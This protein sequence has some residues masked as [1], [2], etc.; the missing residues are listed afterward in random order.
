MDRT[1]RFLT[2]LLMFAGL[3]IFVGLV[4]LILAIVS[5]SLTDAE[6]EPCSTYADTRLKNVPAR[7]VKE[8]TQ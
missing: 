1:D 2:A 5:I 3:A 4:M 7:C 6:S 8:L